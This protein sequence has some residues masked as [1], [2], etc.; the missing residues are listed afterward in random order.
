MIDSDFFY[1]LAARA[2][3]GMVL[4]PIIYWWAG[5]GQLTARSIAGNRFQL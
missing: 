5:G 2:V 4:L 3:A 1:G